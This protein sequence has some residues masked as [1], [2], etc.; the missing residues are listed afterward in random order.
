MI[1][2]IGY[3]LL[4]L[5]LFA[6]GYLVSKGLHQSRVT[7]TNESATVLLNKIEN[8]FKLVTVEGNYSEVYNNTQIKNVGFMLPFSGTIPIPKS[9][10]V[11]VEGKVL[12]GYDM[13]DIDIVVDSLTRT[14]TLLNVPEKAQ[15]IAVDHDIQYKNLDDSF[16]N[17]FGVDDYTK[18]NKKAKQHLVE[19][20]VNEQLLAT[21][22]KQGNELIETVRFMVESAGWRFEQRKAEVPQYLD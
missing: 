9:A 22:E 6:M 8:V 5:A 19:Q 7:Q 15:V 14:V 16:F 2:K 12:V 21:A 13:K 3:A 20:A 4:A 17:R 11:Q 1:K 10:L 18:I